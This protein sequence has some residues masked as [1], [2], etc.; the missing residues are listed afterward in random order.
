MS[1]NLSKIC[2]GDDQICDIVGKCVVTIKL[3]E[4]VW[5]LK[6]V[7]H[8]PNLRKNLISMRQLANEGYSTTFHY[9]DWKISKVQWRLHVARRVVLFNMTVKTC[10]S[11]V[12]VVD[13]N[14][15]NLGTRDSTI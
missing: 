6:Y 12:V 7:R 4:F 14:N 3:N 1:K 5:D 11:I 15:P 10:C 13:N 9:D 8:I 2:L